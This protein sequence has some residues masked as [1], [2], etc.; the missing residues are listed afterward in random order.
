MAEPDFDVVGVGAGFAGLSL[1]HGV[2]DAQLSICVFDKASDIG[3]TWT[4]NRYPGAA[5][6][7]ES[8]Y[9]CLTFSEEILNEWTWS[10]RYAGWEETLRYLHFVADKC[11]MWPHIQLNTEIVRADFD[12]V[13]ELWRLRT[14]AG[15]EVTCKYFVS[16]MGMISEPVIPDIEGANEFEGP[17][18]HSARWPQEGLDYAGKRIGIIGSGATAVQ[19]L[20]VVAETASSVTLFQRTPNHVMPAV[21]AARCML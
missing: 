3:G 19:M 12:E 13:D 21:R 17:C 2:R 6:D 18:F 7:S 16:A 4:W 8:F 15:E 1:I 20:P 9:Y 5:T 11:D 14:A 10:H